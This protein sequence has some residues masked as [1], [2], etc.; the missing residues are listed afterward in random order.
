V[1]AVLDYYGASAADREA[2]LDLVRQSR[3]RGWWHAYADMISE[4]FQTLIGLE[5]EASTIRI[6]ENHLIPGLL[7]T[8]G[9]ARALMTTRPHASPLDVERGL[10]LRS[11]RQE[12]LRREPTPQLWA[13]IDESVLR[14]QAGGPDVMDKQYEYLIAMADSPAVTVQ[15]LLTSDAHPGGS[16]PFVV[17]G[18]PHPADPT[19]VYAELLNAEFYLDGAEDVGLYVEEFDFLRSRALDPTGSLDYLRQFTSQRLPPK[20]AYS[21][22]AIKH[23][24]TVFLCHASQDKLATRNL[25]GRLLDSGYDVW[26]DENRLLPGQ[27]WEHEI[28]AA[29]R[30]SDVVLAL[31]SHNS[32]TKTG[33]V[34]RELLSRL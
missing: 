31:L 19:V 32:T 23:P 30:S 7:Q 4:A 29:V 33:F 2:V 12:V 13:V 10:R 17:L 26:F 11:S 22:E 28:R 16:F 27:D 1:R 9:Y 20:I 5:D 25:C 15:I 24:I 14:R 3:Q 8:E 6:Y 34:Q 21:S 18:F